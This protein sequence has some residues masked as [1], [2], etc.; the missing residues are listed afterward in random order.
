MRVIRHMNKEL[1]SNDIQYM[2]FAESLCQRFNVLNG[3]RR[4]QKRIRIDNGGMQLREKQ[5]RVR[6]FKIGENEMQNILIGLK[7]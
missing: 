4:I 6:A 3:S 7:S 5:F 1:V 2:G